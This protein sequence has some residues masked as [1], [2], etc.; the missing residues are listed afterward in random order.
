MK[1]KNQHLKELHDVF[2]KYHPLA[3]YLYG[4]YAYGKPNEESDLDLLVITEKERKDLYKKVMNEL[5][6]YEIPVEMVIYNRKEIEQK[7]AWNVMVQEV[8]KRGQLIYGQA[9]S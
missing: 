2:T 6:D 5:W 3:V 1:N 8:L 7:L 9:I 4:S